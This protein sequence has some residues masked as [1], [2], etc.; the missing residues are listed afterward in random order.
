[1]E[2]D[3]C[4]L[5]F[6]PVHFHVHSAEFEPAYP[7]KNRHF[8]DKWFDYRLSIMGGCTGVVLCHAFEKNGLVKRTKGAGSF[9]DP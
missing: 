8:I 1:M 4:W 7:V 5:F 2:Q 6:R 9:S 3:V